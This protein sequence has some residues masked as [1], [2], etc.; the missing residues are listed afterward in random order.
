LVDRWLKIQNGEAQMKKQA[1]KIESPYP[2]DMHIYDH[3]DTLEGNLEMAEA[4]VFYIEAAILERAAGREDLV[5]DC[6]ANAWA[7]S[8]SGLGTS[9]DK[10]LK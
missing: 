6:Q 3:K 4:V 5:G 9:L 2:F 10:I 8:R 7:I 1:I